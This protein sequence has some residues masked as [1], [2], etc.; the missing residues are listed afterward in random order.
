MES[1]S[2]GPYAPAETRAAYL[3]FRLGT[4]VLGLAMSSLEEVVPFESVTPIPLTPPWL[5]GVFSLRGRVLPV[6]DLG[7]RLGF[8]HCETG[9]RSCVLVLAIDVAGIALTAGILVDE[10]LE[11]L[12]LGAADIETPPEF[13]GGIKVDFLRGV[14]QHAGKTLLLVDPV[15]VFEKDELLEIALS[16]QRTRA[17]RAQAAA[18][19]AEPQPAAAPRSAPP[20]QPEAEESCVHLFDDEA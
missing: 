3:T 9:R 19:V 14:Y 16:H 4:E 7:L 12:E 8:S 18:R 11:L 6:I 20:A 5:R 13:G 10:V 1:T 15:R 2:L 17:E